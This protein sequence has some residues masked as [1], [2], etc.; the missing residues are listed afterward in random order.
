MSFLRRASLA[1]VALAAAGSMSLRSLAQPASPAGAGRPDDNRFTPVALTAPGALDEPLV[2]EILPDG[3]VYIAERKGTIKVY[4]P[5]IGGVKIAGS[6]AVNT[7]GN[8]EQGLVGITFDPKFAENGWI[9]LYYFHPT[10]KKAVFSRWQVQNDV[11][12][13]NTEKVMLEWEAQREVCCHTGGGMAWDKD[14]NLLIAVG[15]NRGNNSAS[16]TDER[17]GKAAWDDQGGTAN[18]NSLEGKILRI[19]PESDGTLGRHLYSAGV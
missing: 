19:H 2:C 16:Q 13:A 14:G 11:L 5:A 18:S 15:N 9:Y 7:K 8:N 1:A 4:D 12:L 10:Q 3:R 6:L 17:P